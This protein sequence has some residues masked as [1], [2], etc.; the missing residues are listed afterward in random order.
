MNNEF[1][2]KLQE[3]EFSALKDKH[4]VILK[5]A[6]GCGKSKMCIDLINWVV[7]GITH[8]PVSVL[9][10]VAERAHI[11]NWQDEFDKWQ[12]KR[13]KLE[14]DI[15]CYASLKKYKDYTY[16]IIVMDECFRGDVEILT[17]S[18]Y[19]QFKDLCDTDL[20]AQFTQN[21]EIE[22]VKPM[23]LIKRRH[24]GDI[25]KL[26]LGRDRYCYLT[27]NHNMVYKTN[28]VD[29][30]RTKPVSDLCRTHYTRIPVSGRGTGNNA[31]LTPVERLYI[32]IQAD[33]TLQ[34]HQQNESVY[35]IQLTRDRKKEWMK[36]ILDS[37]GS[38]KY[39]K[40]KGRKETDRYLIKLPKGDA[41]LLKTHFDIN[42][43]FV[44][45]NSFI[46]EVLEW[47]GGRVYEG[48]T[49]YYSSVIKENADFVA[50]VAIQAGYKTLVSVEED[51]R[52]A[53]HKP[54][55]RVFMRKAEDVCTQVMSKE[56]LS[57]DDDVYCVEVPSHMI[58]VRSEGYSFIAGN[59]HHAFSEKRMTM[60]EEMPKNPNQYVYLLS[61]TLS[62]DKTS[63]IEEIFGKFTISTVT[64]KD[65][66]K[67]DILPDP[68]VYVIGME[69]DDT[70]HN[71]KIQIGKN[72]KAVSMKWEESQAYR[73]KRQDCI[74]W[75]TEK[76]K[77]IHYNNELEYWKKRWEL[78]KNTFHQ[79]LWK[80]VGSQRKR[81]LGEL[82]TPIVKRLLQIFPRKKR[83]VCFCAT[84]AQ[85]M[86]LSKENTI[87][88][89]RSSKYNQLIINAFNAKTIN[90]IYAVGMITE[91]MNLTDI[92][93]G[94]IVQ[95]DGKE[96]LFLQKVGRSLRA[97]DPVVFIFYY[98]GTQDEVYLKN[99][100][101][102]IDEKF[103]QRININ[104]LNNIKL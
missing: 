71:Q 31:I 10:L 19:K 17:D 8:N 101:E 58:V 102:N 103:I 18:G 29:G 33:G 7:G 86:E 84:V 95:L 87:S 98:K 80:N 57:Y 96:R 59:C 34:R 68:K 73:N 9:F 39:T 61:A 64:L 49:V 92:E 25:C 60:L 94:I 100:L 93:T 3:K 1:K 44:R 52:K 23:R 88:S 14:V 26:H 15:A 5:W 37:Y 67:E 51:N 77:Y 16:D 70:K 35:S 30:W 53:S 2:Q 56:Y 13:G 4:R 66:I 46:E 69:L 11:Q 42:M 12:L 55:Y 47:D 54:V 85:S 45:A 78:S 99:A 91:G 24:T 82:K 72:P 22:F 62:D 21:G 27:P 43:G 63:K 81:Y 50:A 97:E 32:A 83:F 104:Q 48:N 90:Q 6:T 20:V 36:A 65:A 38:D 74:I 40:I 79:N 41:K 28:Y 76:Q 89:K 75:A